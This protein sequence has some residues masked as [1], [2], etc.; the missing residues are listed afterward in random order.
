MATE[1]ALI[2]SDDGGTALARGRCRQGRRFLSLTAAAWTQ[3]LSEDETMDTHNLDLAP[4]ST[5]AEERL[6]WLLH[7][8]KLASLQLPSDDK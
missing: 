2:E 5:D 4:Y 1:R 8:E 7:H 6:A 3:P